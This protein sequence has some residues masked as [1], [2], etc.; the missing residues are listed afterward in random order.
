MAIVDITASTTAADLIASR[1]GLCPWGF[2]LM[3]LYTRENEWKG[4]EWGGVEG[5]EE[6]GRGGEGREGKS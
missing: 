1:R 5:G 2:I 4:K 6:E 3:R